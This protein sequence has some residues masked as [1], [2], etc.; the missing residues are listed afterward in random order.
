[1]SGGQVTLYIHFV[2]FEKAFDSVHRERLWSIMRS[3]GIPCKMVRVIA[4]TYEVFE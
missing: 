1:M 2:D 4:D 3:Y